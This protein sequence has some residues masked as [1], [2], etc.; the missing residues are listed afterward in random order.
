[1]TSPLN[2]ISQICLLNL[3]MV[4]VRDFPGFGIHMHALTK[5]YFI[6]ITLQYLMFVEQLTSDRNQ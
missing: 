5:N 2:V 6:V 3:R 4:L 1:M